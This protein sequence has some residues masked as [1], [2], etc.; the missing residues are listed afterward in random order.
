MSGSTAEEWSWA[1]P[2]PP[3]SSSHHLRVRFSDNFTHIYLMFFIVAS[4]IEAFLMWVLLVF[5]VKRNNG[6][7]P[8]PPKLDYGEDDVKISQKKHQMY[9][10]RN[11]VDTEHCIIST[12]T[13]RLWHVPPYV[14]LG[15]SRDLQSQLPDSEDG[16]NNSIHLSWPLTGLNRVQKSAWP[17]WAHSTC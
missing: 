6:W 11:K 17:Q 15:K 2:P 4:F 14:T 7:L 1:P 5:W 10:M 9:N 3:P 16:H 13:S 8:R 12:K